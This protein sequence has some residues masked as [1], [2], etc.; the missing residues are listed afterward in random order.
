MANRD[1]A[2]A[3]YDERFCR[4]WEYYLATS[5]ISFRY[6]DNMNFQIQLAPD[7]NTLPLA[8][9]YMIEA[10]R[11]PPPGR[12]WWIAR[13]A[14]RS[15]DLR[16]LWLTGNGVE[17]HAKAD[18]PDDG[19]LVVLLHGFPEFWFGWRHQLA[20]LAGAG[21]RVVA[22]DLRGYNLSDKPAGSDAYRPGCARRRRAG[23]RRCTGTR[24]VRGRRP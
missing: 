22:P 24:P 8:R 12:G 15:P 23:R 4:M 6:L 13:P 10:E 18:G 9:D 5:E 17:L 7:R 1:K 21:F 2:A 11:H 19:P 20:P 16:S 14:E 3:L